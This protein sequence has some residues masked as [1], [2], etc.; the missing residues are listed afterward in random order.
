M[1]A[2]VICIGDELLIGQVINTNA[3]WISRE[4]S[5]A[6][7]AVQRIVCVADRQDAIVEA[8]EDAMNR[9]EWVLVTG[10]LGPTKDDVTKH[11]LLRVFGG[12]LKFSEETWDRLVKIYRMLG[13]EATDAHREQA[14][15]PERA[16]ILEN[17]MGTAPGLY[18]PVKE[19]GV[20]VMPGVPYEMEYLMQE[21]V[22]PLIRRKGT[23]Q[24]ISYRTIATVG[25]GE[26]VLAERISDIEDRLPVGLGIAYLPSPGR[27]RIRV[28]GVGKASANVES[29]VAK[30][31]DQIA[32]RLGH[33]VFATEDITLAAAIGRLL[34]EKGQTISVAE[35]CT[36]GYLGHLFSSESG[37]SDYFIGGAI[38]YSNNLKQQILGVQKKTL[39]EFGAVSEETVRE[40]SSGGLRTFGSNYAIAVT[41]IA[42]P[43][44]GSP[45]KPVGTVWIGL[46]DARGII[47]RRYVFG[48]DRLRN[49]ELTGVYALDMLRRRISGL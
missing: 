37:S 42:G 6:G 47:T 19:G 39:D 20:C 2:E 44:G 15:Q 33:L 30:T 22:L 18:F 40:M 14:T 13:K 11:A 9:S 46:A 12:Q 23:Q 29:T 34:R 17:K 36:G 41:G 28:T 21:H 4:L 16:T 32:E 49:I 10:G 8:L 7:L 5:G 31:A 26:T 38:A 25:E 43:S 45:D 27:V 3:A 1:R 24:E 48:K 35:S